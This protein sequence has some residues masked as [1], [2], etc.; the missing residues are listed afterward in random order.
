METPI[1]PPSDSGPAH[2]GTEVFVSPRYL[3]GPR[4]DAF[5]I[6]TAALF[7]HGWTHTDDG[8]DI[9]LFTSPCLRIRVGWLPEVHAEAPIQITASTHPLKSPLWHISLD[10]HAPTE[11]LTAVITTLARSLAESPHTLFTT[12]DNQP[13]ALPWE[14]RVGPRERAWQARFSPAA[15]P[16][17]VEAFHRAFTDP[18]P[19]ARQRHELDPLLLPHL[20]LTDPTASRLS[21]T[22]AGSQNGPHTQRSTVAPRMAAAPPPARRR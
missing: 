22:P 16:V 11:F 8:H 6:F 15:P 12:D 5:E 1:H 17:L 3:A 9:T 7:H 19:L 13:A 10:D 4:D 14:F 18:A 20:T 2:D 21:G